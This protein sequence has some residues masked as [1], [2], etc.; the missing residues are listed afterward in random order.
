[1]LRDGRLEIDEATRAELG[2]AFLAPLGEP[3][4]DVFRQNRDSIPVL[5]WILDTVL[6]LIPLGNEGRR[7]VEAAR[8]D[9]QDD[10]E[11]YPT[12]SKVCDA[13]ATTGDETDMAAAIQSFR[14]MKTSTPLGAFYYDAALVMA[15][16]RRFKPH[17]RHRTHTICTIDMPKIRTHGDAHS[18]MFREEYDAAFGRGEWKPDH[19]AIHTRPPRA[20][21]S[22]TCIRT[23]SQARHQATVP[24]KQW[25]RPCPKPRS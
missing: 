1:M 6:R 16:P 21:E 11:V 14:L 23:L 4:E 18:G 12:M 19:P 20:R 8:A 15:P 22:E 3:F 13:L 10:D 9:V 2:D 7:I 24:L 5:R 17:D 25:E